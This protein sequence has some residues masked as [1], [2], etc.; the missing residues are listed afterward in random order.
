VKFILKG[1][2]QL[3][4]FC[5]KFLFINE[6]IIL[7]RSGAREEFDYGISDIDLTVVYDDFEYFDEKRHFFKAK[8][9]SILFPMIQEIEIFSKDMFDIWLEFGGYRSFGPFKGAKNVDN[10]SKSIIKI[11]TIHEFFNVYINLYRILKKENKT[12]LDIIFIKKLIKELK[13]T[14]LFYETLDFKVLKKRRDSFKILNNFEDELSKIRTK[15]INLFDIKK[16][17][18]KGLY[19]H[20]KV[21]GL[22]ISN[23]WMPMELFNIYYFSGMDDHNF[24]YE[25]ND[26]DLLKFQFVRAYTDLMGAWQIKTNLKFSYMN[27]K[28]LKK[29]IGIELRTSKEIKALHKEIFNR[30]FFLDK[31]F[32]S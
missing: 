26:Q 5:A 25:L 1:Q 11:S 3:A 9:V 12:K 2:Y 18:T 23:D 8:L 13:R 20:Y 4:F 19:E 17:V 10:C 31:V 16:E 27:I 21:R 32:L 29:T 14:L 30:N 6:K 24:I 7:R 15:A 28:K 22:R